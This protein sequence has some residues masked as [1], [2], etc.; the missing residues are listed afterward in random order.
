MNELRYNL[1]L[2]IAK[3]W[4]KNNIKYAVVHGLNIENKSIGRDLDIIIDPRDTY[5]AIFMAISKAN[6]FNF[7]KHLFRWSEWGLYQLV[8]INEDLLIS[9]PIDFLSTEKIW[10]CK[11]IQLMNRDLFLYLIN[12]NNIDYVNVF[13]YS[14]DGTYLKAVIRPLLCGDIEKAIKERKK[15][16]SDKIEINKNY[17]LMKDIF[18]DLHEKILSLSE[19][20]LRNLYKKTPIVRK[21]QLR[22]L[23]KHPFK[24]IRNMFQAISTKLKLKFLNYPDIILIQTNDVSTTLNNLESIKPILKRLFI[25]LKINQCKCGYMDNVKLFT[26]WAY[27]PI[28]EFVVNVIIQK[29]EEKSFLFK[30]DITLIEDKNNNEDTIL[31]TI[32]NYMEKKYEFK[33]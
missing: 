31:N 4:N 14:Y 6:E 11:V 16:S 2:E 23:I 32:L 19:K 22:W 26:T 15:L 21:L 20:D 33:R 17:N 3:E 7:N 8:L 9:L 25:D 28:S 5:K 13:K 27:P 24:G 29:K 10:R 1:A 30:R 18:G 12:D